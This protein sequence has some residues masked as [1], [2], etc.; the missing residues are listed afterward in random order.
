[1]ASRHVRISELTVGGTRVEPPDLEAAARRAVDA[2][3]AAGARRGRGL[4]SRSASAAQ[5]RVYDGAVESLDRR[6]QPRR[7]PARVRSTAAP[8]TRTAPTSA[9]RA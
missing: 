2:A 9:R 1:M 5:I 3:L 7:R 4:V 6:R 8:A